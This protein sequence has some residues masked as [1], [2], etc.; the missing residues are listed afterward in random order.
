MIF[1]LPNYALQ[2]SRPLIKLLVLVLLNFGVRQCE[3]VL[4]F[5]PI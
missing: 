5:Q 4:I 1:D 3:L 2:I